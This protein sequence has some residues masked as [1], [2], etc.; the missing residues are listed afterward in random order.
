M[1]KNRPIWPAILKSWCKE[2]FSKNHIIKKHFIFP[3][4]H[5]Y[6]QK[7]INEIADFVEN[8]KK[9]NTQNINQNNSKN[10]K[11]L[12]TEKDTVKLRKLLPQKL[13]NIFYYLPIMVDFIEKKEEFVQLLVNKVT[14]NN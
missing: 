13:E 4:H 5:E 6:T 12:T 14:K 3:D 8:L 2:K 10:I 9:N 1:A 7:S 11:I